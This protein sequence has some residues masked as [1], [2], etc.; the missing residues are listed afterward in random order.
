MKA[1]YVILLLV[2]LAS[3]GKET[4]AEPTPVQDIPNEVV[5]QT[6]EEIEE[7]ISE[8]PDD[9]MKFVQENSDRIDAEEMVKYEDKVVELST[10]YTNPATEVIMNIEYTLDSDD[11]IASISV[12]SPNYKGMPWFNDAVQA[13]VGMSVA[14]ASQYSVSGSSLATPAFQ[15]ALKQR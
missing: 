10:T 12:T 7:A 8:L 6:A 3:C 13:V 14:D 1:F 15:N 9:V 4:I 5:E 2:F 11:T